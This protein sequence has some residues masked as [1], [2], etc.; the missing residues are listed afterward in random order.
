VLLVLKARMRFTKKKKTKFK[1][2]KIQK[3][4]GTY[5]KGV[6][7]LLGEFLKFIT[8]PGKG[9]QKGWG[10]CTQ[11]MTISLSSSYVYVYIYKPLK[12]INLL[13]SNTKSD[14]LVEIL[15]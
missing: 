8:V 5:K 14:G 3:F 12:Y 11:Y 7:K 15:Y 9:V 10:E 4:V 2:Q 1:R 6:T 13:A